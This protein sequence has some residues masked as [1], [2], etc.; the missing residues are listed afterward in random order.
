M[1][2]QKRAAV[3]GDLAEDAGRKRDAFLDDAGRQFVRFI[4]GN[5]YRLRDLGGLVLI[6]DESDY[7]FIS[8]EGAFRSRTRHQDE[9]GEWVSETEDIESAAELVEIYNPADL[10]AAFADAA[11]VEAGLDPQPTAAEDLLESA[12]IASSASAFAAL[13]IFQRCFSAV[14]RSSSEKKGGGKI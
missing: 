9:D 2:E 7:L 14:R 13:S 8:D 10:Y 6:D 3:L 1:D 11:R 12:G 4:D 5:K